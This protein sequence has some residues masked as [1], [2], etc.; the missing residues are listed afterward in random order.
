MPK[1]QMWGNSMAIRI[2]AL[3]AQRVDFRVGMDVRVRTS[4]EG[5]IILTPHIQAHLANV[6]R[7]VVD[8]F[9]TGEKIRCDTEKL[10]WPTTRFPGQGSIIREKASRTR[11][12]VLSHSNYARSFSELIV[13]PIEFRMRR[14]EREVELGPADPAIG[15]VDVGLSRRIA[16]NESLGPDLYDYEGQLGM[17]THLQVIRTFTVW[18]HTVLLGEFLVSQNG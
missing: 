15:C 7:G 17:T 1:V 10:S 9:Y 6:W 5:S 12:L 14:N 16:W 8:Q 2:P 11:C 13:T 3:I 18:A 4:A